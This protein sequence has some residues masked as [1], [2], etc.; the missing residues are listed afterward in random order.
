MCH[1]ICVDR[2]TSFKCECYPDFE[3]VDNT[4]CKLTGPDPYLLYVYHGAI[5]RL[6]LTSRKEHAV[7]SGLRSPIALDYNYKEQ[8]VY[9]SD[10]FLHK[11]YVANM[12]N[13]GTVEMLV[14]GPY[15]VA[16]IGMA[17]DWIHYLLFWTDPHR[18][19]VERYD[20]LTKESIDLLH[21]SLNE[22]WAI[23][24]HPFE[25]SGYI[26]I[27]DRGISPK[28]EKATVDGKNRQV[29]VSKD[30]IWPNGLTLDLYRSHVY[31]SD[32]RLD[33]IKRMDLDG[34]NVKT[35]LS[36]LKVHPH[37]LTFF[38]ME[39]FWTDWEQTG[40]LK[41]NI[42]NSSYVFVKEGLSVER[43][44]GIKIVHPHRQPTLR[45]F[46]PCSFG[47]GGCSHICRNINFKA[48]CGCPVGYHLWTDQKACLANLT[49]CPTEY[50]FCYN[51]GTCV[52]SPS[53]GPQCR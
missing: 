16:P 19:T 18:E 2:R 32:A 48:E 8:V 37:A 27:T 21:D 14:Q 50:M 52:E 36:A 12:T 34:S 1:H 29:L 23:A 51:G 4:D 46:S 13:N 35:I 17:Y 31:W 22:P 43:P 7:V 53:T 38:D 11:I 26:Y 10:D 6:S 25:E 20:F 30:I 33:Y 28:I 15:M 42:R 39:L 9:F 40:I 3:P 44:L 24:V 47:N 45:D 5:L 49:Q 41:H